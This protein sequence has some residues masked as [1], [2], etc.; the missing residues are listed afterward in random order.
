MLSCSI[1]FEVQDMFQRHFTAEAAEHAA[2]AAAQSRSEGRICRLHPAGQLTPQ[3]C[4]CQ[5][6]PGKPALLPQ[7]L[8]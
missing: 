7:S 8:T 3:G 1:A 4:S 5:L 6:P 2:P